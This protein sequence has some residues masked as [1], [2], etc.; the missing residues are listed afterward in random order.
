MLIKSTKR[1]YMS[2]NIQGINL[3]SVVS[4]IY[5]ASLTVEALCDEIFK[6]LSVYDAQVEIILSDDGSPDNSWEIIEN[7]SNKDPKL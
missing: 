4:P 6:A 3:I 1:N 7:L 2:K 5:N